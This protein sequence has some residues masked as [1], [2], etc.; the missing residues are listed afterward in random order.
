MKTPE[1]P[2][3]LELT[4]YLLRNSNG[5]ISKQFGEAEAGHL[6]TE[7][8]YAARESQLPPPGDWDIWLYLG[9]RGA[10]KTRA[11]AE[12]VAEHV[13]RRRARRIGLIAATH[14]EARAVMIEGE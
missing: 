5:Q 4:A 2:S 9:G 8:K 14:F 12:W 7:W 10:G 3:K 11:G 13:R 1:D 6:L